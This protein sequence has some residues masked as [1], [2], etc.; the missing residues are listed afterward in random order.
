VELACAVRSEQCKQQINGV[1]YNEGRV[2][3][4]DLPERRK[5]HF[6]HSRLTTATEFFCAAILK[7]V[8]TAITHTIYM[9]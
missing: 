6:R 8:S 9:N 7:I 3:D 1:Q 2:L 4:G 5:D